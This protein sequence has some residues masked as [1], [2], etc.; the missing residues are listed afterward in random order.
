MSDYARRREENI[1]R[2]RELLKTTMGSGYSELIRDL[3]NES[4]SKKKTVKNSKNTSTKQAAGQGMGMY[5]ES[6]PYRTASDS[7][8][9]AEIPRAP[10]LQ[11]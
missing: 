10:V 7:S 6:R 9:M 1:A 8:F 3:K 4:A 2:N 11:L 5:G